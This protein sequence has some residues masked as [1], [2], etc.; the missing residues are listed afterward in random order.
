MT[1]QEPPIRADELDALFGAWRGYRGLALAVSGGSDSTALMV[2]LAEWLAQTRQNPTE[3]HVLI[4][5]HGLRAQ[6]RAEAETVAQWAQQR[7]FRHAVLPW[8]GP[9][10]SSGVQAAAR[11]AR[12]RLLA[13]YMR[14]AG[15]DL[16]MTAHTADDQAETLLMRLA[17]GSGLDGLS[18]IAPLAPLDL[19][20][21][22]GEA[23]MVLVR[24]LL[25]LAKARLQAALEA[26]GVGWLEDESNAAPIFER[27][28]VRAASETLHKLGLTG[29]SLALTA[30]RLQR[31][32]AALEASVAQFCAADAGDY[33]ID[34]CGFI[35]IEAAAFL[36][37]ACELR[38][39]VLGKGIAA[40]GGS[41]MPVPLAKL[42][43][44]AQTVVETLAGAAAQAAV[45]P[46]AAATWTLAR[47]SISAV[48][49]AIVLEREP[50]RGPGSEITLPPGAS[51]LW[52]GRFWVAAGPELS[53]PIAVRAVGETGLSLLRRQVELPPSV[54]LRSLRALP[55]FW[56]E[57]VLVAVPSV[58]F[59]CDGIA[60][61]Y[62]LA[63]VF[64]PLA[65][66]GVGGRPPRA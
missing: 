47:A 24:P 58:N 40:V 62:G 44:L 27:S 15:L 52:D 41:S 64:A 17:R 45:G 2:L 49:G 8:T 35:R 56:K 12:Y 54:P 18:A 13:A 42:E 36:Q 4:V 10:P 33:R 60:N 61:R 22:P 14:S 28:K 39:R 37:L 55:G 16:L 5:D 51:G 9:K 32:R 6:S 1:A 57:A 25:G 38:L 21:A 50:G 66:T 34:P 26:R 63:A 59:F 3:V 46:A 7:K 30:R 29:E 11:A 43:A 48:P 23:P 65:A 53:A 20:R 19:P 31:A